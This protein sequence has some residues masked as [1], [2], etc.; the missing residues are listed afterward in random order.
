MTPE[1]RER[2]RHD[3]IFFAEHFLGMS[4]HGGQKIFLLKV[5]QGI[6]ELVHMHNDEL[7]KQFDE[8]LE[9]VRQVVS[10]VR[11][12]L[13]R[14]FLLV[15]AN[16]WGKSAIIAVIQLWFLFYKFGIKTRTDGEWFDIEYRTANIAPF[17]SLTEPVF[18]A[19]KAIMTST[20]PIRDKET[21]TMTTNKCAIE[22]FYLSDKTINNPPYKLYFANNSY[23]EHLSLMGGKGDNLQGKPYGLITYDEAPRSDH[24]QMELDNSVLGRLLDWTAPLV[25]LGTP[26]QDSNSL[27]YYNDLYKE[28]LIG[29]NSSYTQEGSIYE[30]DFMTREQ[31][32]EHEKMLDGNPLKDQML[33]GKFIFG[34]MT[35][36]PGQDILDAEDESLNDGERYI[37]GHKYVIGV[38]TAIGN[39]E[40][41]YHVL[42]VT[43]KPYRKVWTEAIKGSQRSPQMHLNYLVNLVEQYRNENNIQ[44]IIETFN[45]E[46]ARFYDDLPPYIKA[47]THTYGTWQPSKMATENQNP[48]PKRSA[49]IKKAD[50]IV[51]LKKILASHE[52][53]IPKNDYQLIKQLSI[54]KENDKG[55][56]TDRVIALALAVWL[57]EDQVR[58]IAPAWESFEW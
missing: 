32:A 45:G 25:L 3:P 16:R 41:V 26:D 35:I 40:M 51:A 14:R 33:H 6:P 34:T 5:R 55:L 22:P 27:L 58:V 37:E 57:A 48:A 49:L 7:D 21:G 46:S 1:D 30:N 20:Y 15:C 9:K 36:F 54:Y 44:L 18:M 19:M 38:D 23:I 47:F 42:D 11:W 29:V 8:A 13:I 17:S 52:L 10:P 43:T 24:L 4:L 12:E 31:I 2:G 39:D 53:K 56:P 50:I 28:G